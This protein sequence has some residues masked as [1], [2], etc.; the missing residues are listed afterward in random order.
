MTNAEL[1]ILSLI[2]EAPR[3]GYEIEQIIQERGMREWTEIGFSS[4]Y[5]LLNK[6]EKKK[7]IESQL[8]ESDGKGP[9]KKVYYST[10]AGSQICRDETLGILSSPPRQYAP[11]QLGIA[12]LLVV[13]AGVSGSGKS[14]LVFDTIYT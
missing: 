14:S 7:F 2:V 10:E 12:N 3:H 5:Y 9:A 13:F 8:Q 6:L 11:I 1:A 4:I